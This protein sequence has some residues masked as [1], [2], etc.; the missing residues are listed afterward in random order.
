MSKI[1][2]YDTTLRDGSQAEEI[3][4]SLEDKLAIAHLLD[5]MGVAFIEG[6]YPAPSN[7]KDLEF[8]RRLKKTPL[9]NA[10]LVAFGSTRRAKYKVEDDP[11]IQALL[12]TH[13]PVIA[14]VGK[15][16]DLHVRE[17]LRISME[18]NLRMIKDSIAYLKSKKREVFFDAEHFYDA[19]Q[20][21]PEYTRQ[22][23]QAATDGG[24]DWLVLCDTNGGRMPGEIQEITQ[25]VKK[26]FDIP[27]GIHAHNDTELAVANSIAAVQAGATMVQGTINGYG[28]RCGNA[29]LCSVI[30]NLQLKLKKKC[31]ATT[32]LAKLTTVSRTISEI[33]NV[34]PREHNSYVGMNAFA[35]KGGLHVD[36][37]RKTPISYEHVAPETV[38]NE[39]RII[40]SEQA[41]VASVL[42]KAEQIGFKLKPGSDEAKSIIE[43]VKNL[44]H[45]GYKFEGADAS[46]R[47]LVDRKLK[48]NKSYYDLE[49]YRVIDENREGKRV[50]EATI[51]LRIK[52]VLVHT[53]AEG[54]GPVNAMDNALRKALEP[55][56]PALKKV[57]LVDFKVRVLESKTGTAAKVRVFIESQ[58]EN[59]MWGTVGVS[60]NIIEASWEALNDSIE[61]KLRSDKK[62]R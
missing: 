58:D 39:R 24:A 12:D 28:E 19:Y 9:K 25:A 59:M 53:A 30:P 50:T 52:G 49:G 11:A 48:Q 44:E 23:L 35:H 54:D 14:V 3:E 55:Y 21:N 45:A 56:Y 33:A 17:V 61:Y 6:G 7:T 42:F 36:A 62:W 2:I 43:K 34:T 18:E 32:K 16:W 8:Y 38:G 4:F 51:K 1:N 47:L 10:R 15:T 46:F 41:G 26:E 57:H 60:T 5:E 13:A 40:M 20:A 27:V 29:N 31:I 22:V 37:V